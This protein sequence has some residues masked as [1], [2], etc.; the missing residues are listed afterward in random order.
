MQAEPPGAGLTAALVCQANYQGRQQSSGRQHDSPCR[1]TLI[2][3]DGAYCIF[4]VL[5]LSLQLLL[6]NMWLVK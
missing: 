4:H 1:V 2:G 6:R 3:L 5:D